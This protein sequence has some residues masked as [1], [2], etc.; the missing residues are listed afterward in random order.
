MQPLPEHDATECADLGRQ[1]IGIQFADELADALFAFPF[2]ERKKAPIT[3]AFSKLL[4][5]SK[6]RRRESNPRPQSR[7]R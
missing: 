2:L 3:G 1:D 5:L 4:E 6:W 7:K